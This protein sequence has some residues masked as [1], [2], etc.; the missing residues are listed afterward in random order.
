MPES[1][2]RKAAEDK[3]KNVRRAEGADA[4]AE[5]SRRLP[6]LGENRAWVVPTFVALMLFGV[7]WLVVW[8]ITAATG[9][10]IPLIGDLQSWNLLIGMGFIIAGFGVATQ[11]K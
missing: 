7:A 10:P 8:Y 6:S 4:R 11:W 5:K 3:K 2:G 1:K 9:T